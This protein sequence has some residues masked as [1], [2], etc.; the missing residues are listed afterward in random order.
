VRPEASIRPCKHTGYQAFS[1]SMSENPPPAETLL[2]W[3]CV[4]GVFISL[5]RAADRDNITVDSAL[6]QAQR[7]RIPRPLTVDVP[8]T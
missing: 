2:I 3:P 7:C 8:L 5:N 1:H 6:G 4:N